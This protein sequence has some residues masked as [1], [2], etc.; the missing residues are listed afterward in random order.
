VVDP[1]MRIRAALPAD[2]AAIGRVQVAGWQGGYRG[3]IPDA[4]LDQLDPQSKAAQ[5]LER[6]GGESS[7]AVS[8]E[9]SGEASGGIGDRVSILVAEMGGEV[10]GFVSTGADWQGTG[11]GKV[12]ALYVQPAHW[13]RG[14]GAALLVRAEEALAGNG[15][16]EVRLWVLAGN[17]RARRFYERH[18]W[19]SDGVVS[20]EQ[21]HGL[22]LE[23]VCYSRQF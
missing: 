4:Q 15:F 13:G 10:V 7:G 21:L 16:R 22:T 2:A 6:L 20:L 23:E 12:Y 18:G 14:V 5:W 1:G 8:G 3:L 19:F 11:E 17:R 9:A